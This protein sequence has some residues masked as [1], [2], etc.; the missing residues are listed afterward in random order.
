MNNFA[1]VVNYC[2]KRG[3]FIK[4]NLNEKIRPPQGPCIWVIGHETLRSFFKVQILCHVLW[5]TN[6]QH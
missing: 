4:L 1:F 5:D 6:M 3:Q 2:D